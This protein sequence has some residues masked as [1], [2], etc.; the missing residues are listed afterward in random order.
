MSLAEKMFS[1]SAETC[2]LRSPCREEADRK[3][4]TDLF[5]DDWEVFVIRHDEKTGKHNWFTQCCEAAS[6]ITYVKGNVV[7]AACC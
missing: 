3:H 2:A 7:S 6:M 5:A 1:R 4:V